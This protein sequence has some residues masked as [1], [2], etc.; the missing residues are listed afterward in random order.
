MRLNSTADYRQAI[1]DLQRLPA[2]PGD[3]RRQELEA[4]IA[5]YAQEHNN[6]QVRPARPAGRETPGARTYDDES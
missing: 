1:D 2:S 6:S 4:A 3:T 5:A